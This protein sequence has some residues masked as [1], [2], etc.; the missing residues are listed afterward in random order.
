M[1]RYSKLFARIDA[2]THRL[3][4]TRGW[5]VAVEVWERWIAWRKRVMPNQYD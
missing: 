1:D 2:I 4:E 5:P 3:G